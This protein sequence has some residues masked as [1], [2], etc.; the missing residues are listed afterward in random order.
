MLLG[1]GWEMSEEMRDVSHNEVGNKLVIG[2]ADD[3]ADGRRLRRVR[4]AMIREAHFRG[5]AARA[6]GRIGG[7]RKKLDAAKRRE[8]HYWP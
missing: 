4:R 8:R 1:K 5:A 7:R 3:D 6:E 2:R